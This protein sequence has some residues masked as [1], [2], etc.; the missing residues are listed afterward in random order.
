MFISS[1]NGGSAMAADA[2]SNSVVVTNL[3]PLS[4]YTFRMRAENDLGKS[5]YSK[6]VTIVTTIEGMLLNCLSP[7]R[8]EREEQHLIE[9]AAELT[10]SLPCPTAPQF[11]PAN[12]TC[13]PVD[14]K[15][16][17]VTWTLPHTLTK[18]FVEGFYIGYKVTSS[19]EAFTYKTMHILLTS[20]VDGESESTGATDAAGNV[21][22]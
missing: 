15:S 11:V 20:I 6:D 13:V 16:V 7:S 19:V 21:I 10:V 12:V 4:S 3:T 22:L 1:S 2:A 8:R 18:T 9:Y 14:S 17:K 5:D